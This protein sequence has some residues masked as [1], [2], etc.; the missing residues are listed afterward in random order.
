M[1]NL[2]V[3]CASILVA[4]SLA[5]CQSA[6]LS[7]N[8]AT[9][10]EVRESETAPQAIGGPPAQPP[11][12]AATRPKA[13]AVPTKVAP[14]VSLDY[15]KNV[16]FDLGKT[17]INNLGMQ[18]LTAHTERLKGNTKLVVT[19]VGH[20]DNLGS[21]AYNQAICDA[22]L[23]SVAKALRAQG[24]ARRQIRR[25]SLGNEQRNAVRCRSDDCRQAMRRVEL[26]YAP[27][28]RH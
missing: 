25:I 5:G 7:P 8:S 10:P 3:F 27:A 6:P 13:D 22:R 1:N 26:V 15:E 14:S 12:S 11:S 20:T 23:D 17:I 9:T 2:L 19:L 18:T 16:Y 28:A 24:V 4:A 21:S